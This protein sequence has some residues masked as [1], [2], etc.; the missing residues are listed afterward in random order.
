ML[1]DGV[2]DADH[3]GIFF[4]WYNFI[5]SKKEK[6]YKNQKIFVK[7]IIDVKQIL[8]AQKLWELTIT[9]RNHSITFTYSSQHSSEVF[10]KLSLLI[11]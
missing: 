7:F 5:N 11:V 8:V 1:T 3:S 10:I 2:L 4:V 6:S 9:I